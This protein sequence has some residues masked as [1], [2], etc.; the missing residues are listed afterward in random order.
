TRHPAARFGRAPTFSRIRATRYR[1]STTWI[2]IDPAGNG[3]LAKKQRGFAVGNGYDPHPDGE[4]CLRFGGGVATARVAGRYLP[5]RP[6][7]PLRSRSGVADELPDGLPAVPRPVRE[8]RDT[9]L[10]LGR[11]WLHRCLDRDG[12]PISP[13]TSESLRQRVLA[14]PD[15]L[16]G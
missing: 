6:R 11:R 5:A 1:F 2:R 3:R 16:G 15:R 4:P 7:H 9:Y 8:H 13:N 10:W 12:N 14:Q